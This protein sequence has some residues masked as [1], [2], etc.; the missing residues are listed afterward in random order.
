MRFIKSFFVTVLLI[1]LGAVVWIW[2][3]AYTIGADD[4]HWGVTER[5]IT[6][7]RNRSIQTHAQGVA[8][9]N[10]DDPKQLA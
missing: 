5:A 2:S 6:V 9:P 1:V 10:L 7:L 4:P 3:G 8:V